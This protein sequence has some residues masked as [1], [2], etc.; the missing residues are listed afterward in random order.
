MPEPYESTRTSPPAPEPTRPAP[1]PPA[2][3]GATQAQDG[4]PAT[5]AVA[6]LPQLPGYEVQAE[7]GRGGM[8][9]VYKARDRK[10]NRPV[11]IKMILDE[12][13]AGSSV[14]QRFLTEAEAL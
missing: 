4:P 10:L 8:G 9:V 12:V 6:G 2:P 1:A 5:A 3:G 11:A 14:V 7:L 13:T